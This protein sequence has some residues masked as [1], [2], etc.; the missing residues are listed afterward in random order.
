ME[1]SQTG[2]GYVGWRAGISLDGQ[3]RYFLAGD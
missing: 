3:W 1:A 2:E